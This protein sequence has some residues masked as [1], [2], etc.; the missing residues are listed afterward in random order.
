MGRCG[1]NVY[2]GWI[3]LWVIC[4]QNVYINYTANYTHVASRI[5]QLS[6]PCL[7]I[8]FQATMHSIFRDFYHSYSMQLSPTSTRPTINI[9]REK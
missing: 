5:S 1:Q 6:S 7:S 8:V 4:A 3:S 2:S 9:T